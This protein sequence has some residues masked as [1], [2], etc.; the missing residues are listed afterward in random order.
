MWNWY[1]NYLNFSIIKPVGGPMREI[2]RFSGA[3][4]T[5]INNNAYQIERLTSFNKNTGLSELAR[6]VKV[7]KLTVLIVI[8][9]G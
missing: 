9:I 1:L 6:G 3:T 7:I 4:I 8:F 5:G 2:A